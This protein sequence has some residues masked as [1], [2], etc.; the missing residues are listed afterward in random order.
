MLDVKNL[1]LAAPQTN[2]NQMREDYSRLIYYAYVNDE[3]R[4]RRKHPE[5]AEE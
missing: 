3:A 2:L 1:A 5:L 4:Y